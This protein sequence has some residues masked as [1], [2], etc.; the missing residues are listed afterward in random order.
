MPS[1]KARRDAGARPERMGVSGISLEGRSVIVAMCVGQLGS[2]LPAR[3]RA[4]DSCRVP[5]SGM[6]SERRAGR[7]VGGLRRR[8]LHADRA[9]AGDADRPHRCAQ[10]PD[11]GLCGQR[12]RHPAVRPLCHRPV[13][14]RV[15]Q[16]HRRRRLCRRLH[17]R[18]QGADRP[19]GAGR[20]IAR[21]HALHV[22]LFVRRRP[23][24]P[25]FAARRG[26]LGLARR[27]LGHG[28]RPAGDADRSASC[29]GRSSRSRRR[30]AC[31]ISRR[32]SATPRPWASF[33]AM[34]RIASSSTA[35]GPG[36]SRSGPSWR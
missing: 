5:D 7:P 6:A 2:L 4:V 33:S 27:I 10:N 18:P 30:A 34:A 13:V 21:D 16:R 1:N 8:R 11:R 31:W 36:S 25:G 17:A 32:C 24:V 35:S 15:L 28:R 20:F 23:V 9:G 26:R 22:E 12:A 3:R 29:C 19:P 14:G